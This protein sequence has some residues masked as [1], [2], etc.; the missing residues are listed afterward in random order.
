MALAKL[1]VDLIRALEGLGHQVDGACT[2]IDSR[3]GSPGSSPC[4][5]GPPESGPWTPMLLGNLHPPVEARGLLCTAAIA[6]ELGGDASGSPIRGASGTATADTTPRQWP[7]NAPLGAE[8]VQEPKLAVLAAAPTGGD[9]TSSS[10][11]KAGGGGS[12]F[13]F[14]GD[15][16]KPQAEGRLA[17]RSV[18][19]RALAGQRLRLQHRAAAAAAGAAAGWGWRDAIFSCLRRPGEDP[20]PSGAPVPRPPPRAQT[21]QKGTGED[22]GGRTPACAVSPSA[23]H[24]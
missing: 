22:D 21:M 6:L 20:E 14:Q 1:Q 17:A 18:E 23:V 9:S 24:L 16:L 12:C 3:C 5:R 10:A 8:P 2:P 11:T 19:E 7:A 15:C 4:R 13:L